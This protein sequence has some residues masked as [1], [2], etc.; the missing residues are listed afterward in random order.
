[1]KASLRCPLLAPTA[2][3]CPGFC[4]QLEFPEFPREGP[5]LETILDAEVP[6]EYTLTDHRW[7]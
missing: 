1:V 2:R 4:A 3:W 7:N 6:E 5:K